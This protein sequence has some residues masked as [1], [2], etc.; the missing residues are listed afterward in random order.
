MKLKIGIAAL[1][2]VFL[3]SMNVGKAMASPIEGSTTG[4]FVNPIGP[5]GMIT[6]GVGTNNFTWGS[7]SPSS[8]HYTG[9]AISTDFNTIFSFGT[10]NYYNGVIAAGTEANSVDLL[11][12][13][14]LTTPAGINQ[15]FGY[16][17]SL[18]NTLNTSDPAAS[19]DYVIFPTAFPTTS[20]SVGGINYTLAFA[21]F[22]SISSGGF[23]I[24]NE[25]HVLEGQTA[26]AQLLGSITASQVPE[27][28][29]LLLLGSGLLGFGF[30]ARKRMR[31]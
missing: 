27:P 25:F 24:T 18:I 28:S 8:L 22:G 21:G 12:N 29:T 11:V 3:V 15:N 7:G 13:L 2:I 30:F 14:S 26:S 10:L 17:L 23:S 19:A 5:A 9:A 1:I 4:I 31:G 20:F 6:T 16:L